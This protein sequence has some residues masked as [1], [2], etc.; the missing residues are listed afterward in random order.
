MDGL[1]DV[2]N[3]EV[4]LLGQTINAATVCNNMHAVGQR[5]DK[6]LGADALELAGHPLAAVDLHSRVQ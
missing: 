6:E 2:R 1:S 5:I 3:K 4:L